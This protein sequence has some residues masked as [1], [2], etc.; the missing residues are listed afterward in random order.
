MNV[1]WLLKTIGIG[2]I[3][4]LIRI[5]AVL[6]LGGS[7]DS[8]LWHPIDFIFFGLSTCLSCL[9]QVSSEKISSL[10]WKNLNAF[11]IWIIIVMILLAFELG[12]IYCNE[13]QETIILKESIALRVAIALLIIA[14]TLSCVFVFKF[15][16][17]K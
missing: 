13:L 11:L 6:L 7:H 17:I 1:G 4:L 14:L 9:L 3:P 10:R 16:K 8:N 12:A 2:S 15:Q 5:L